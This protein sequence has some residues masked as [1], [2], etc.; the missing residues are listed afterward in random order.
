MEQQDFTE[1]PLQRF[2]TDVAFGLCL[3][4]FV[5]LCYLAEVKKAE[6]EKEKTNCTTTRTP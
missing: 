6:M 5:F 4:L 1:K 3:C 2:L